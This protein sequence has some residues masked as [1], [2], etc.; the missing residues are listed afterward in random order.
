MLV[1]VAKVLKLA[2]VQEV[3]VVGFV[4]R[5]KREA[6]CFDCSVDV[7]LLTVSVLRLCLP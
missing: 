7:G 1:Q 6:G 4:F 5:K 3:C 2:K